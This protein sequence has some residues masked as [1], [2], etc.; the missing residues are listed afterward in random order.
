MSPVGVTE[1]DPLVAPFVEKLVPSHDDALFAFQETNTELPA[2]TVVG[3]T[4]IVTSGSGAGGGGGS[5]TVTVSDADANGARPE[6]LPRSVLVKAVPLTTAC[7][8]KAT[9]WCTTSQG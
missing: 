5:F 8:T 2:V 3:E 6:A 4:L 1:T 7:G 9:I